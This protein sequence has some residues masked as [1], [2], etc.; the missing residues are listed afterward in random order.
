[1]HS[2]NFIVNINP[3]LPPHI[4]H[5]KE[6]KVKD[7]VIYKNQKAEIHRLLNIN[8]IGLI[9]ISYPTSQFII[10]RRVKCVTHKQLIQHYN[11]YKK[12]KEHEHIKHKIDGLKFFKN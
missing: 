10:Q 4:D 11:K 12:Y 7:I 1:M 3:A 6:F 9:E 8:N 5:L 2:T